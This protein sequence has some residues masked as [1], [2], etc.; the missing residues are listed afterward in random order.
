[1]NPAP[2]KKTAAEAI[3][4]N[5]RAKAQKIYDACQRNGIGLQEARRF[6]AQTWAYA[7]QLAG[8]EGNAAEVSPE[9]KGYIVEL[10]EAGGK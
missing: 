5:R 6:T 1:M 4:Q 2:P 10:F 7:A 9:T 3:A 8:Y